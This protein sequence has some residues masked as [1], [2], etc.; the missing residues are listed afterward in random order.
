MVKRFTLIQTVATAG[1]F[2]AVSFWYG[3]MI[4]RETSRKELGDL[5]ADLRRQNPDSNPPQ[6]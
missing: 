3:F 6:S 1:L 2:S 4:G 5:I